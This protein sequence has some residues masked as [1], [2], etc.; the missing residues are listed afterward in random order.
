MKIT[1]SS[2]D[3]SI[4]ILIGLY[5]LVLAIG[6]S[7]G[8]SY[9]YLT[10]EMTASGILEQYLGNNNEWTPKLPKT[11]IDLVS[12]A[13]NHVVIFSII[14]FTVGILFSFNTIVK[15]FWKSFLMFEPFCSIIITFGGFFI[16]RFISKNFS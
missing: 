9:I 3:K 1:L 16:L 13:H 2:L 12:S 5:L 7:L 14:F 8:L 11:F 4:K 6:I 15:G 10:T